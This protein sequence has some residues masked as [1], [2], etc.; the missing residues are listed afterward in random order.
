M[1]RAL[2][3]ARSREGQGQLKRRFLFLDPS[4]PGHKG[5]TFPLYQDPPLMEPNL[6]TTKQSF[7]LTRICHAS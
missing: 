1:H 5:A 4:L 3:N 7:A 6:K 2:I